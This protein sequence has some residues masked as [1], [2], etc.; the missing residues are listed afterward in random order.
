MHHAAIDGVLGVDLM[1]EIFDLE[2][3]PAPKPPADLPKPERVPSDVELLVGAMTSIARQPLRMV[4][5][6]RNL[7]GSA[8][9]VVQRIRAAP[10][11]AGR[12]ADRAARP[13]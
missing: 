12:A 4:R 2:P 10:V 13:H 9:R 6:A 5:A 7:A 8:T 1:T 3:N 11:N